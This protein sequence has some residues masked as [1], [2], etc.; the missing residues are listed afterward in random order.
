M[1]GGQG[2]QRLEHCRSGVRVTGQSDPDKGIGQLDRV[3][4]ESGKGFGGSILD[5][6]R[7]S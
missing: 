4:A 3:M 7:V 2:K 6:A 5:W 1:E